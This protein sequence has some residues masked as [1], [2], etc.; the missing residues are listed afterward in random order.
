MLGQSLAESGDSDA[1]I[2]AY[3]HGLDVAHARGDK[4]VEKE[5]AVYL[6]RIENARAP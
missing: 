5:I 1:A 3:R 6:R 4:Q 2:R